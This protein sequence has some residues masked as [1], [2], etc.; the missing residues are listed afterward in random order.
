[1][2]PVRDKEKARRVAAS[3]IYQSDPTIAVC[4]GSDEHV[5]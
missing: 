3:F 5:G 4:N 1:M 2:P